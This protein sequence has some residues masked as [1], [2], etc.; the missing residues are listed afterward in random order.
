MPHPTGPT[1]QSVVKLISELRKTKDRFYLDVAKCLEKSKR[2]KKPVN[3]KR[4]QKLSKK[5]KTLVVPG[6]ILGVGELDKAVDVYA[7]S[8]SKEAV[9]KIR[10]AGGRAYTIRQM[11]KDNAKGKMV[12]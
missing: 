7:F 4:L 5:Y 6:K 8:Y 11:L 3:V 1:N 12:I 2:A 9:A 10:K